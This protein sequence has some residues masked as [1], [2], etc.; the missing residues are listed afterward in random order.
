[1]FFISNKTENT[2]PFTS[3]LQLDLMEIYA[4]NFGE[5]CILTI[6]SF[7]AYWRTFWH[8]KS[9][10]TISKLAICGF[11]LHIKYTLLKLIRIYSAHN[12][13]IPV[14][15]YF[16]LLNLLTLFSLKGKPELS[17]VLNFVLINSFLSK[18]FFQFTVFQ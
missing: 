6:L 1:M 11:L 5:D 3:V 16:G 10:Y 15:Y 17:K 4:L 14:S 18:L 13:M 9:V 8:I 12:C 2:R 7:L